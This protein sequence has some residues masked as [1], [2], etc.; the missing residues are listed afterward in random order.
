[1]SCRDGE[2]KNSKDDILAG[3]ITVLVDESLLPIAVEQKEVFESSYYNA[4]V[5]LVGKPEIQAVN[6]LIKGEA[7]MIIL[8]RELTDEE[9]KTFEQRSIN[10]RI[11]SFAYDAV[12]LVGNTNRDSTI[13]SQ[14]V[15]DLLS[16]KKSSGE[17]LLIDNPNSSSI[18]YFRE[19]GKL[20]KIANTYIEVK[21]SVKYILEDVSSDEKRIGVMSLNQYLSLQRSFTKKDKIRILSVLNDT[22]ATPK[23]VKATQASLA[24]GE[25][26]LRREVK[27]LN[28]QPNMGLG[29]GFSAFITGDRGQRIVLKSGLLPAKMPGREI[30]IR[31]KIN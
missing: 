11:Y 17:K 26:P 9:K 4:K 31:D 18:R 2:K 5:N 25:Y 19:L 29:L 20:D 12:V 1:M 28:Y 10:P 13:K 3:E 7:G 8:S 16:G 30:I 22:L 15:I 27:V 6:D 21:D 24:T 23:Y 14:E